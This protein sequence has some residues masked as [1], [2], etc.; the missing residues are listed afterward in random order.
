VY[1]DRVNFLAVYV[2]EAHPT[3][4]WRMASNDRVGI[5]IQQPKT[6]KERTAVATTCCSSLKVT[7]PMVVDEMDDRV[8][9]AYSGMPDR[10]YII[11]RD[12]RITYKGGRGPFGFKVGEM[13]QSLAMLLLDQQRVTTPVPPR[14]LPMTNIDAWQ[15]LPKAETGAGSPLPVWAR[16]LADA[17][18]RT[19]A[20]MLELDYLH[21]ARSP[22]DPKLRAEMRWLAAHANHCTYAEAYAA[23]D[24]R[25][26]GA[27]EALLRT[28]AG[29]PADWPEKDR[30]ALTFA[31]QLTLA[32]DTVSDEQMAQL[33]K[34]YGEKQVVAM[35]LL[36]AYANFQDRLLLA[37]G[38]PL[39]DGGP[40][41]PLD[42]RFVRGGNAPAPAP[43]QPPRELAAMPPQKPTSADWAALDFGNL[44]AH[45]EAQRERPQRIAVPTWEEVRRGLPKDYPATRPSR[46]K[47]S[48]VCL[49]Y[50]PELSAAWLTCMRTFG[51]E[52]SQ[53]RV[54]EESVFWVITRSLHCFY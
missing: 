13:E 48:L 24:L 49:G 52:S 4:G 16:T 18:P 39:E 6:A 10:L 23:A 50:Q 27:D 29:E 11:D 41:A 2:R 3:D 36:L 8:G 54:F 34:H 21:R 1:R 30:A 31:R 19:T 20:L 51:D 25:R 53:D 7:M 28:L 33:I 35:V 32:A 44:Q 17:L 40:L 9:H 46:I 26:A 42:V 14:S 43:R 22:L 38:T 15:R 12:G 5:T 45:L 37:L 47:W